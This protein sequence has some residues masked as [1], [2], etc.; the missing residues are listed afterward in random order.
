MTAHPITDHYPNAL[1]LLFLSQRKRIIAWMATIRLLAL[2]SI[3]IAILYSIAYQPNGL[4]LDRNNKIESGPV[5]LFNHGQGRDKE[6]IPLETPSDA[7]SS[8]LEQITSK[9]GHDSSSTSATPKA[10]PLHPVVPIRGKRFPSSAQ[11]IKTQDPLHKSGNPD[12]M[13][14]HKSAGIDS[15]IP[16]IV[17]NSRHALGRAQWRARL[18]AGELPLDEAEILHSSQQ[19]KRSLYD[20]EEVAINGSET[21]T[22]SIDADGWEEIPLE[23]RNAES[24]GLDVG[25][26]PQA[27]DHKQLEVALMASKAWAV[28][29][30]ARYTIQLVSWL[31]AEQDY[32]FFLGDAKGL[33][34]KQVHTYRLVKKGVAS[35]VVLYGEYNSRK[36]VFQAL[37]KLPKQ[38]RN[39]GSFIRS[40]KTVRKK[41]GLNK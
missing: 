40:L 24:E 1:S 8:M 16:R 25:H 3:A 19:I 6:T 14:S 23:E 15:V 12:Q 18:T 17:S 32:D 28:S 20:V 29:S 13:P 5:T 22:V 41:M 36:E 10:D 39:K 2:A 26:N 30:K 11:P 4:S 27:G 33:D 35:L 9:L 7:I 38:F 31:E 37:K 21:L 34:L